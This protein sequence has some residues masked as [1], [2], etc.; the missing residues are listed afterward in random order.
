M[1]NVRRKRIINLSDKL[2]ELKEELEI[3]AEEEQEYIDNIPENLQNSE[4]YERAD[5][6]LSNLNDAA[7]TLDEVI[8]SLLQASE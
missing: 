5:E 7:D 1:N 3:I 2:S 6:T 4:R 8:E